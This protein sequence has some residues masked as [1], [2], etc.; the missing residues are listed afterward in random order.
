MLTL[1]GWRDFADALRV[2]RVVFLMVLKDW[3][4]LGW[5]TLVVVFFFEGF[6]N[7]WVFLVIFERDRVMFLGTE[8]P[9]GLRGAMVG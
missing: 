2:G 3:V 9:L 5:V 1:A 6:L 8:K 4:S 7:D